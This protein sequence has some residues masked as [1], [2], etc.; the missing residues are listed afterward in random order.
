MLAEHHRYARCRELCGQEEPKRAQAAP[1][2][3]PRVLAEHHRYARC[4]ELCGQEEPERCPRGCKLYP[5]GAQDS[6]RNTI[7]M[8]D[9]ASC[10]AKKSPKGVPRGGQ[11]IPKC[12]GR[13]SRYFTYIL[14]H[15]VVLSSVNV[16]HVHFGHEE[17]VFPVFPAPDPSSISTFWIKVNFFHCSAFCTHVGE[18]GGGRASCTPLHKSCT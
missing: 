7:G 3:C 17:C 4:R 9:V 11:E 5:R 13:A 6:S 1:K 18:V 8:Q 16:N 10:V 15:A 12:L 14:G 2:R